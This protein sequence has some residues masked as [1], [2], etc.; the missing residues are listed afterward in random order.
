MGFPISDTWPS[1]AAG[2]GMEISISLARTC[3]WAKVWSI[4]LTGPHG[5]PIR[6]RP[7]T[8]SSWVFCPVISDRIGYSASRLRTRAALLT[9]RGSAASSGAPEKVQKFLLFKKASKLQK[10]WISA[11]LVEKIP[12]GK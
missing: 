4:V 3:G 5:T 11:S 2:W 10:G 1:A 9:K 7:S 8:H 6:V 12:S